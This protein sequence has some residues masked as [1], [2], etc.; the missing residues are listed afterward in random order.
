MKVY[1][2]ALLAVLCLLDSAGV[3]AEE[4]V[5]EAKLK[6]GFIVNFIQFV[7]WPRNPMPLVLCGLGTDRS[8]E[9]REELGSI[10]T[11]NPA[12]VVLWVRSVSALDGCHAVYVTAE[13]GGELPAV[14]AATAGRPVL[15]IAD[16]D[17]GA[18]LGAMLSLVRRG[19]GQLGFDANLGAVHAAGLGMN[20]RLLQL[21]RR[22]Y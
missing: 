7:R 8:R 18:P 2:H 11:R 14:V 13:Q 1:W 19:D 22:V 17:G 20:S 6:A 16:L 10:S 3:P 12:L 21:A 5:S 4:S 9:L 15:V